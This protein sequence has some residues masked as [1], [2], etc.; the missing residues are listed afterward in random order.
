[1]SASNSILAIGYMVIHVVTMAVLYACVK[2]LTD[3]LSSSLVVFLY[4]IA[5]LVCIIPWCFHEGLRSMKTNR[6]GLHVFRGF[7]SVF[8]QICMFYGVK[9]L[10]LLDVTAIQYLE[11]VIVLIIGIGYFKEKATKT[12]IAAITISVLG[13]LAIVKPDYSLNSFNHYFIFVFIGLILYAINNTTIK[14]LGKT[15]KTKVQLFYVTLVSSIFAFPGAF[16]EWETIG[17]FASIPISFPYAIYN[18]NDV[19]FQPHHFWAIIFM[20]VCYFIHAICH[21]QAFKLAE[22]STL[23]PLEYT[24]LI[25]AGIL[26]FI[27]FD[28]A[29]PAYHKILGYIMITGAGLYLVYSERRKAKRAQKKR[30]MQEV[31]EVI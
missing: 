11:H 1:M 10:V 2:G 29:I 3:G 24:R 8:A 5:I 19:G 23:V 13:M 20:S 27:F 14:I 9:N 22:I 16:M 4:K 21:F 26:G 12:K 30:E 17:Y 25:F 7:L 31:F 18:I 28:D 15:E 6:I